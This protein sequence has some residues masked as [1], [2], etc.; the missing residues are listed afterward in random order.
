MA[1]EKFNLAWNLLV[2]LRKEV[3]ELQ[4]IRSQVIGFKI[5]FVSAGIGV[6]AANIDKVPT[7]LLSVPAFAAIFFDLLIANTSYSIK[8]IGKFCRDNI[9]KVLKDYPTNWP[10]NLP[11]WENYVKDQLKKDE[12]WRHRLAPFGNLGIT[13][14]S[15]LVA[16]FSLLIPFPSTWQLPWLLLA[17]LLGIF[18]I[19]DFILMMGS[20]DPKETERNRGSIPGKSKL[21]H[22]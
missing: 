8:R 17:T 19:Y 4:R 1:Q 14:L 18:F 12:K 21:N 11:L 6:I 5:T 7:Q 22:E 3:T 13:G 10:E 2:E 15:V 9:E 16:L 20:G